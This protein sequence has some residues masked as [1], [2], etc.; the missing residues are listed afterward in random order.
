MEERENKIRLWFQ[1]WL[2]KTDLGMEKIFSEDAVY[3]ESWGPEYHGLQKIALWFHEWNQRGTVQR[4]DIRQ[5][6]HKDDQTIVEWYFRNQMN[7]GR[8]EAFEGITLTRWNEDGKI[9]F[10][11]EFGCNENRY[12]PYVD[13]VQ[14]QFPNEKALWF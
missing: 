12:D 6:I 10:L 4:W 14:P 11:Q 7:D 9:V 2:Q 8:T 3:L 5:F 1:M 13:G